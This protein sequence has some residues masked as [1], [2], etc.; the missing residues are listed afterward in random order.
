MPF[1]SGKLAY[2]TGGSSGIGLETARLL[3]SRGCSLVLFARKQAGLDQARQELEKKTVEPGQRID[4]VAMDVSD[5]EDVQNKIKTAVERFGAPDILINSAGIGTAGYFQDLSYEAFDRIMK[6]NVY[7]TRNTISA[8]L[9]FMKNRGWGHIVNLSSAAGLLGMF[10]YS[11]YST[12]KYALVGLSECLR[13][14]LKLMNIH[15]TVVCPPEV[16]TPFVAEEAASLPPEGRAVKS[17]A[18]LLKPEYVARTIVS[19]I[20]NKKFLVVPGL[21]AKFLCLNHRLSNGFFTH[22]FSDLL[23]AFV[24]KRKR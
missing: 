2:I 3:V 21:A 23:V 22:F 12:S 11:Y 16:D 19:A 24:A 20:K 6:I 5:N 18:G 7:G 10:G 1:F 9:P 17:L 15:V 8:V 4:T 14:E 13:S